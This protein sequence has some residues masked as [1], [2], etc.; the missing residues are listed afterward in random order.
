MRYVVDKIITTNIFKTEAHDSIVYGY[1]YIRFIEHMLADRTL[2][3]YTHLFSLH[4]FD[5]NN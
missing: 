3:D 5:K 2:I 4:D 1:F